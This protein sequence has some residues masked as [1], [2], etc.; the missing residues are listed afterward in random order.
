MDSL[1]LIVEASDRLPDHVKLWTH[2]MQAVLIVAPF[3]FVRHAPARWLILAQCVNIVI[4]Y[5]V[6][7]AEGN[8]VTKIFGIGHLAWI[9]P[10]LML[11]KDIRPDKPIPYKIFATAAAAT[12]CISLVFDVRD[13]AQWIMGERGSVLLE[14][15]Q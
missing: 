2:W 11:I 13:T 6:F 7:I 3:A 15:A 1:Q 12:I 14:V 4:G 10:L 5:C 8:S 9:F